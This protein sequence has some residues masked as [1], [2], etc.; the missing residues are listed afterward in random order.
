MTSSFFQITRHGAVAELCMN[1]PDKANGMS[2]DFWSDLPRLI[3]AL[4]ADVTCRAVVLT[5][6]GKHFTGG[7]DLASFQD[8]MALFQSEPGR[9]AHALRQTILR[10]Q[11]A[12]SSLEETRLP[13]IAA[14]HGACIGG[15]IDMISACDIRLATEDARFSIEEINIGMAADVGTLQRLPKLIPM[16]IVQ[17]LAL[18]GRRFSAD[19]A[20]G[21]GLVNALH[22]NA[23]AVRAAALEMAEGIAAKS[24]LA[25]AGTKQAVVYARDHAVRD[26]LDQIATWNGGMLRP[27]DLMGAMQARMARKEAVFKDLLAPV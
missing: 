2:P 10:L 15:G 25:V 5:G 4:D 14:I 27:E 24:P 7:M 16:G 19:E 11:A 3:G 18:T 8:L 1:R 23:D 13:V 17:E 22:P 21:W 12:L 20:L 26:G 9:G 6:A